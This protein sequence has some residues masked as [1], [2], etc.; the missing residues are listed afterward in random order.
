M[1]IYKRL[2]VRTIANSRYIA[3]LRFVQI[4]NDIRALSNRNEHCQLELGRLYP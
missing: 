1:K 2:S 4:E 3:P